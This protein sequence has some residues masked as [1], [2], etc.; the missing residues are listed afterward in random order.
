M[1]QALF[2]TAKGLVNRQ[3]AYL[4]YDMQFAYVIVWCVE[5]SKCFLKAG[6]FVRFPP[7]GG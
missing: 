4:R 5:C 2:L 1:M 6:V 3:L 7:R